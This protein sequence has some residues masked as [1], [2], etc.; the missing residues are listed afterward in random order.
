MKTYIRLMGYIGPYIK[1]MLVGFGCTILANV[2]TAAFPLVVQLCLEKVLH[3]PGQEVTKTAVVKPGFL[4]IYINKFMHLV[5]FDSITLSAIIKI[6]LVLMFTRG[7]FTFLQTYIM[8]KAAQKFIIDLR[9]RMYRHLQKLSLAYFEKRKTG[10]VMSNLTND[11][12]ALQ[13]AIINDAVTFVSESFNLIVC[14]VMIFVIDWR[15]ALITMLTAPFVGIAVGTLGRRIRRA[16]KQS[17]ETIADVT[18]VLKNM[19]SA[20]LIGRTLIIIERR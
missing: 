15:L 7:V 13:N 3:G 20:D 19:R 14:L 10:V 18:S 11:V 9:E 6:I 5:G 16:G 4:D 12:G 1:L 2:S 17:Q 8:T